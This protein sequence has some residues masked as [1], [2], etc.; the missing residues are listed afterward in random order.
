MQTAGL[1][2]N[3]NM[4]NTKSN[5][6]QPLVRLSGVYRMSIISVRGTE[7]LYQSELSM[8]KMHAYIVALDKS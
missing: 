1:H 2:E 4:L 3:E 8:F 5:L 7:K 6:D